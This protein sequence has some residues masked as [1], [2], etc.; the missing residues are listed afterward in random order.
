VHHKYSNGLVDYTKTKEALTAAE[1]QAADVAA[2]LEEATMQLVEL[3]KL[4]KALSTAESS[5]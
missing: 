5:V 1:A 4:T 2:K 3:P